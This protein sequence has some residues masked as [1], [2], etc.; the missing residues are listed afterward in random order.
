[1]AAT[2]STVVLVAGQLPGHHHGDGLERGFGRLVAGQRRYAERFRHGA[3]S[4]RRRPEH[5]RIE[6]RADDGQQSGVHPNDAFEH[7]G[8]VSRRPADHFAYPASSGSISGVTVGQVIANGGSTPLTIT[9][10]TGITGPYANSQTIGLSD[11]QSIVGWTALPSQSFSASATIV[12]NRVVTAT[13]VNLGRQILGANLGV[14][15]GTTNLSSGSGDDNYFTRVT[16]AGTTF[17]GTTSSGTATASGTISSVGMSGLLTTFIT[18]GEGLAGESP[19]NVPVDYIT[20]AVQNRVVTASDL[21]FGRFMTSVSQSGTSTLATSGG[22]DSYTS[23]TVAG[24]P[25]K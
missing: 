19:I 7:A 11:D 25:F 12:D 24:Q 18:T 14:V 3:G 10:N 13:A 22:S 15:S 16:V 23:I 1:M 9:L 20:T 4:C 8:R 2:A 17:D 6:F 5:L 21:S